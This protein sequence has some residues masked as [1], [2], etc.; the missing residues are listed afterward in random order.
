MAEFQKK[1]NRLIGLL[2]LAVQASCTMLPQEDCAEAFFCSL[3]Q[4]LADSSLLTDSISQYLNTL[5]ALGHDLQDWEHEELLLHVDA[6]LMPRYGRDKR[7]GN[8]ISVLSTKI[9]H[10]SYYKTRRDSLQRLAL[11]EI[12]ATLTNYREWD[13]AFVEDSYWGTSNYMIVLLPQ[14]HELN[15]TAEEQSVV[16]P[17]QRNIIDIQNH[18]Y[19]LGART[20]LYEGM[21][22]KEISRSLPTK[23]PLDSIAKYFSKKAEIDFETEY[24][25]VLSYGIETRA[26]HQMADSLRSYYWAMETYYKQYS[27]G[28][29]YGYAQFRQTTKVHI[30]SCLGLRDVNFGKLR[31]SVFDSLLDAKFHQD[32]LIIGAKYEEVKN[33]VFHEMLEVMLNER[34][35]TFVNNTERLQK[36]TGERFLVM[37][38]GTSHFD[39][40][41]LLKEYKDFDLLKVQDILRQRKISYVYLVPY[42]VWHYNL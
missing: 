29:P 7:I 1:I 30:D 37:K 10:I 27:S 24:P 42:Y 11:N 23:L 2:I 31:A 26:V 13:S 18:L 34:N 25:E 33:V 6:S 21:P 19:R 14:V 4:R 9:G 32:S 28:F 17:I 39:E 38:A 16:K 3:R 41:D 20:F 22:F 8:I 36:L 35:R 5:E 12:F 15:N 40:A